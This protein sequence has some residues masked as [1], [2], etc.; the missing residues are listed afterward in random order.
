MDGSDSDSFIDELA[1]IHRIVSTEG[2]RRP[3]HLAT[4]KVGCYE[5]VT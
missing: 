2:T 4:I 1:G 5:L 3:F